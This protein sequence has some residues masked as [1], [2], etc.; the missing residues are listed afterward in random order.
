MVVIISNYMVALEIFASIY[1]IGGQLV[2]YQIGY[3]PV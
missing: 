2:M 3:V 1:I